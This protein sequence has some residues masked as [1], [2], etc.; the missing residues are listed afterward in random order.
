MSPRASAPVS[1]VHGEAGAPATARAAPAGPRA[2]PRLLLPV[3]A[4]ALTASV[5]AAVA[6]GQADLSV[7]EV[8]T[9]LT[10]RTGLA[11]LR[12]DA[13]GL[14][15]EVPSPIRAHLVWEMRL[16]RALAA[17][18]I[19]GGLAVVGAIMQTLTRNPLADPYLLGISSGA[20]LGAV[21]IIVV[22]LGAGTVAVSTGA[23]AGALAAF[24]LVLLLGQHRGRLAPTRLILAGVA[25]G[26]FCAAVTSFLILWVADAQATHEV[27]FWV[28]GSLAAARFPS[29][30]TVAVALAVG[31]SVALLASRALNAFA[32]G[33]DAAASL[34]V[35]VERTRWLLLVLCALLTGVLVAASG[36]IGF[37]G[38]LVPHA[39]R[40][41]VGPDH[42]RVLP[43]SALTGGLFLLWVDVLARTAFAPRELPV[44]VVTA[45]LGVPAFL[46]ILRRK[47][48]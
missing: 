46:W 3:G 16:P 7:R 39:V 41:V 26:A 32:F 18:L 44:G 1:T 35:D 38:L 48:R 4:V 29:V 13:L 25:V 15:P 28:S 22:G 27:Q 8:W 31:L 47:V 37:V 21:S 11:W 10:D 5:L 42:R 12:L 30:R 9:V 43:L 2:L 19:G 45:L 33:E 6:V 17:V 14:H 24:G 40:A 23:F 34:G 20:S 36:T